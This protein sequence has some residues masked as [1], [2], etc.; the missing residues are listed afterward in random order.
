MATSD[1]TREICFYKEWMNLQEQE[2]S[3]LRRAIDLNARGCTS[4]AELGQLINKIMNH[5]QNYVQ[6]RT[7]IARSDVSPY[8]APTWCSSLERSVM[9]IGG[10]RP[11]SYIRLIYALCGLQIEAE[12]AEYI[13]G[14]LVGNLG[15]LSG[16]QISMV[17]D[18]QRKTIGEERRLSTRMAGLQEDVLDHP[19]AEIVV[20]SS[21]RS[22]GS[23]GGVEAALGEHGRGMV[24]VLEEA[25]QLRLKTLRELIRILTPPQ[26]VNFLAAGKKLQLCLRD[27]GRKRDM[28]HGRNQV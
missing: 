2:L 24:G 28:D 1:Q 26:A 20:E 9:W 18:L 19:L 14:T 22:C 8:F 21:G 10:C 23:S 27:W 13:R 25:D 6:N 11:S 17:D 3:E 15:E 4:D 16:R 7:L 12:L 5:F